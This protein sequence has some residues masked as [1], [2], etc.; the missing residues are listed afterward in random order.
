MSQAMVNEVWSK[1]FFDCSIST[2]SGRRIEVWSLNRDKMQ[3]KIAS[4]ANKVDKSGETAAAAVLFMG[5]LGSSS[6][7]SIP[8]MLV[9]VDGELTDIYR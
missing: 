2:S 9:F 8:E 1:D 3:I 6:T 7:F 5:L 4:E